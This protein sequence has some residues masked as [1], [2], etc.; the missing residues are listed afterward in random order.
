MFYHTKLYFSKLTDEWKHFSHCFFSIKNNL[1]FFK[2]NLVHTNTCHTFLLFFLCLIC[3]ASL[4][5]IGNPAVSITQVRSQAVIHHT[6]LYTHQHHLNPL[7]QPL[8]T[9]YHGSS[10]QPH[11]KTFAN[12]KH[13]KQSWKA[14]FVF[15]VCIYELLTYN[16]MK[17]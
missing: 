14:L 3:Y 8:E 4:L 16:L 11:C 13:V 7:N 10:S 15:L 9:V 2:L 1:C 5:R 6:S 12:M 17:C